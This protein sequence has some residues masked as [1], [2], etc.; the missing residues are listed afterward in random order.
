MKLKLIIFALFLILGTM[1]FSAQRDAQ[2]GSTAYWKTGVNTVLQNPELPTGC[3]AT[4]LTMVL[5]SLGYKVNKIDIAEKYLPRGSV[6]CDPYNVFCGNPRSKNAYGCFAP[7]IV[8]A[9]NKC[10]ESQNSNYRA[11]D[12]SG[13][14]P[15]TLYGYIKE[16]VPVLV[17]VTINMANTY[18]SDRWIAEDTGREI[19]WPAN[20]HCVVLMG[21]DSSRKTV[22][23]NDP[24]KGEVRYNTRLFES[25]YNSMNKNA[26]VI[27]KV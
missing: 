19:Q 2:A 12:I 24:L 11:V 4:S 27:V 26:V 21:Y 20:E 1:G 9:A 10:L 7:V 22:V 5:N 8:K 18:I 25:R 17:W 14:S 6:N 3:E 23:L 16:G 15:E 13:S